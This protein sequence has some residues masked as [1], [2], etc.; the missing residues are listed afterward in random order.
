MKKAFLLVIMSILMLP[1]NSAAGASLE[2]E[3][4][5]EIEV[6]DVFSIDITVKNNIEVCGFEC[7]LSIP[8]EQQDNFE[9]INITGNEGLSEKAGQFYEIKTDKSKILNRFT[10]FDEPVT[11]DFHVMTIQLKALDSGNTPLTFT[12]EC[13]DMDGNAVP[14]ETVKKELTVLGSPELAKNEDFL[15]KMITG[16]LSFIFGG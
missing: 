7:E 1:V 6:G 15:S 10:I 13:A 5:D 8:L 14:V 9:I 4:P 16:L 2:I 12:A 3:M 11:G